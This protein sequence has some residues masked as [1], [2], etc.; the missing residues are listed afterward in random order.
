VERLGVRTTGRRQVIDVTGEVQAAVARSGVQQGI[1]LVHCPHTTASVVVNERD[2]ALQGDMLDWAARTAP[3]G[4]WRH[5]ASDGN[6]HAHLQ[7]MLLNPSAALPV[8]GARLALGTWQSVLLV[9]L[10]GPRNRELWVQVVG[11]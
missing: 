2:A 8:E 6:G 4:G 5:D 9:E 3:E 7:G 1:A 11:R 10:D